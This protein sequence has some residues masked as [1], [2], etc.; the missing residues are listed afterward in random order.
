MICPSCGEPL[1]VSEDGRRAYCVN[2]YCHALVVVEPEPLRIFLEE[3]RK[4][5]SQE[6][7]IV[8]GLI[9]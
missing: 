6:T 1:T 8:G 2:R 4:K 5:K 3:S 7:G 9:M